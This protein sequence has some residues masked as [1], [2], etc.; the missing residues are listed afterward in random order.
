MLMEDPR[1]S[2]SLVPGDLVCTRAHTYR[3]AE[4]RSFG[5]SGIIYAA[6]RDGSQAQYVLKEFF[7][8]GAFY[9]KGVRIHCTHSKELLAEYAARFQKENDLSAILHNHSRR[10]IR[11]EL[12]HV[13]RIVHQEQLYRGRSVQG[14][15]FGLM[16]DLAGAGQFLSSLWDGRHPMNAELALK[17]TIEVLRALNVCHENHYRHGD[18][19]PG[20]LYFTECSPNTAGHASLLD[21][22][23]TTHV[24]QDGFDDEPSTNRGTPPFIPPE[25]RGG[26]QG[27]L[28][29]DVWSAARLLLLLLNCSEREPAPFGDLIRPEDCRYIGCSEALRRS[30]NR[31]LFQALHPVPQQRREHY[32]DAM[33][34]CLALEELLPLAKTPDYRLTSRRFSTEGFR[35]RE[36]ELSRLEQALDRGERP[37]ISGIGGLGKTTL[38]VKLGQRLKKKYKTYV[39]PFVPSDT[40]DSMEETVLRMQLDPYEYVPAH[41]KMTLAA[42]RRQEFQERLE[43]LRCHF[44]DA[45][46][47][48]DNVRHNT[49][50]PE[51]LLNEPCFLAFSEDL[52][53]PILYTTRMEL[54][55]YSRWALKPLDKE[56]LL[57]L[58]RYHL[59][60]TAVKESL[61]LDLIE[62]AGGHTLTLILIA[63]TLHARE[64]RISPEEILERLKTSSLSDH[65]FADRDYA[66]IFAHLRAL[67]D[68]SLLDDNQKAVLRLVLQFGEEGLDYDLFRRSLTEPQQL[69]LKRLEETGWI[70]R[71]GIQAR[72]APLRL[73]TKV[74][75]MTGT[76]LQL[77]PMI[78]DMCVE[79]LKDLKP[80]PVFGLRLW[81]EAQTAHLQ[82]DT[83][84]RLAAFFRNTPDP[85]PRE[86]LHH[87]ARLYQ[88]LQQPALTQ[89]CCRAY[90]Q[91][92][93]A[94]PDPCR[95]AQI[96]CMQGDI[97]RRFGNIQKAESTLR[98]AIDLT[99]HSPTQAEALFTLGKVRAHY[100]SRL[101]ALFLYDAALERYESAGMQDSKEAGLIWVEKAI[102]FDILGREEAAQ[103]Q[104]EAAR[105]LK[106]YA[107]DDFLV[108]TALT[109]GE[110]LWQLNQGKYEQALETFE[111]FRHQLAQEYSSNHV[112]M[113]LALNYI[114]LAQIGLSRPRQALKCFEESLQIRRQTY[115]ESA[116]PVIKALRNVA[117]LESHLGDHRSAMEHQRQAIELLRSRM[118]DS[119]H[120]LSNY[121]LWMARFCRRAALEDPERKED[122]LELARYWEQEAA[123]TPTPEDEN[124]ELFNRLRELLA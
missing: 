6:T 88:R 29:S 4:V 10:I 124:D 82:A 87:S 120:W 9:R 67:F 58:M 41:S 21:F 79:Q 75:R 64:G 65:D 84:T 24:G 111:R 16:D 117:L 119:H 15:L 28:H 14:C 66:K 121:R 101:Q 86:G 35:N 100:Q 69:A 7:P 73:K 11:L 76:P 18:L 63:T 70:G 54:P 34:L 17:V 26:N 49:K 115:S 27:G 37:I 110:G 68:L 52:D 8:A 113:A 60:G 96:L 90:L 33:S 2:Q 22:T 42:M 116:V 20:N 59:Q 57:E 36:Q 105:I 32:P 43:I 51:E 38:C 5:G 78:W 71:R 19:S 93:E 81:E 104:A 62:E 1:K 30:L 89:E 83:C 92:A 72:M 47:I 102:S 118:G 44:S 3:I 106:H 95:R 46:F 107:P 40:Y 45:L 53:N 23:L 91:I 97:D 61:L 99:D 80:D 77:H 48:I 74:N 94:D 39:I 12:I 31:V 123:A 98:T 25:I 55:R 56:D 112:R 108:R 13:T 114:G 103:A 50:S 122:L 85:D 109:E